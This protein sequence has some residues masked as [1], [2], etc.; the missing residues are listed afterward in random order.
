MKRRTWVKLGLGGG[1]VALVASA[2][3]AIGTPALAQG[4]AA[5]TQ[6]AQVARGGGPGF[7]HRA[8]LAATATALNMTEAELRTEME[9]G[10]SITEIASAKGIS[11]D[12]VIDAIVTAE[13]EQLKQAVTDGRMTQAQADTIIANLKLTLPSQLQTKPVVGLKGGLG[14]ERGGRGGFGVRGASLATIATALNMTEAELRTEL[15]AGKSVADIAAAKNVSLDTVVN[16]I[17]AE[18]TTKLVQ[19]VTDGKLTQAQADEQIAKLKETLPTML[20]QPGLHGGPGRGP[21]RGP[22]GVPG[23]APTTPTT[24]AA[25]S[26]T[27]S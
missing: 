15:Q 26:N 7:G 16:A 18:H 25:P 23:S 22:R 2:G 17:V 3:L 6:V 21:G 4:T 12:T 14:G 1:L 19:A 24:P 5:I 10:K 8:N 27:N 20:A 9:A 11:I 13:T